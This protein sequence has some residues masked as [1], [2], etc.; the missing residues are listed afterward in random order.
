[1]SAMTTILD[2]I[3]EIGELKGAAVVTN[4]G[5][6][7]ASA[8]ADEF[9]EDVVAALSSFL[10]STTVRA[11]E[12]AE[13]ESTF[14]RFVLTATHGKLVFLNLG[15]AFLVLMANQ[16]ADLSPSL[17]A[18]NAAAERLRSICRIDG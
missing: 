18:V 7:V 13:L 11:L 10:I 2:E 5:I 6:I 16:F 15:E 3:C 4:D 12:E 17:D 8:L 9:P 1:M 14:R